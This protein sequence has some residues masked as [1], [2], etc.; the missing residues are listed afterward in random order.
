M[1]LKYLFPSVLMA[2]S[3]AFVACGDDDDKKTTDE[4]QSTTEQETL[5]LSQKLVTINPQGGQ[6][7]ITISSSDSWTIA[8]VGK[9]PTWL[10]I[11]PTKGEAGDT[12][13]TFAAAET[14]TDRA[15]D[16]KVVCGKLSSIVKVEQAGSKTL[17]TCQEV[18]EGNDSVVFCV[19]GKVARIENTLYGNWY[20]EDET[21]TIYIYGTLDKE[22]NAGKNNSIEAWGIEV[23]DII[24]VEGK[25]LTYNG[26]VELVNVTVLDIQKGE[27]EQPAEGHGLSADDPFTVA[28]AL[29]KCEE[30][31]A[32]ASTEEYF[33]KGVI[34]AISEVS[35]QYGNAT[36]TISDQGKDNALTVYRGYYLNGDHFTAEDQIKI[37]DIVIIGGH[38]VN[39]TKDGNVTPEFTTGSKIYSQ[40]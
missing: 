11:T 27:K 7:E 2:L 17:S 14:L 25:K 9:E 13:V 23:G 30:I 1:K 38:L 36:Y 33:A 15:A 18:I 24:M 6:V 4:P 32:T 10:R 37:G 29:A 40:K 5:I 31:G 34:T 16:F 20:L 26:K 19:K 21:G 8:P 35:T 28:E 12:K 39:Y 3:M 22:G